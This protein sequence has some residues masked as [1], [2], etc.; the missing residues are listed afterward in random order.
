MHA[1]VTGLATRRLTIKP[2]PIARLLLITGEPW[3][4]GSR[5]VSAAGSLVVRRIGYLAAVSVPPGTIRSSLAITYLV[6]LLAASSVFAI[7]G[8]LFFT[9]YPGGRREF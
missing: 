2:A 3:Y 7:G 4:P 9:A 8:S 1:A 6:F 5:A